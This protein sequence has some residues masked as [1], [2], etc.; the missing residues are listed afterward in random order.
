MLISYSHKFI[1]IH[2]AKAAGL[3]IREALKAYC[4]E[5]EH[6]KVRRPARKIGDR[7]NPLYQ[8]WE[9]FLLHQKARDVQ[10]GLTPEVYKNFYTFAFARNP[11][12]WQVSM[13][14]FILR[15]TTHVRHKPVKSMPGFQQYLE[16]VV[17]TEKPFARGAP[18]FQ[19]DMITDN[20]GK[21]IVDFVG[22]YETLAQDFNHV[23]RVLD[24]KVS[25]PHINSTVH[26]DYRSFYNE[27]TKKIVA[28]HFKEDIRLFGY[29]F[30]GCRPGTKQGDIKPLL[31]KW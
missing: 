26:K 1:F 21:V 25:L 14:H 30:E 6:F 9:I 8:M 18:K 19:K 5:P 12:D 20:D 10:K 16:W 11:W 2:I 17:A 4:R 31:N 7:P 27:K 23:C 13:Y 29:T 22:R 15:E 3:S 28:E 24:I